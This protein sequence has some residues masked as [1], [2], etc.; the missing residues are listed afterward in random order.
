M[1]LVLM[2]QLTIDP[3]GVIRTGV[4][5]K[6]NA[7]HQPSGCKDARNVIEL[8][9]RCGFEVAVRDLE[10]FSHIWLVW[11]FDRNSTWRP[12]V[13][14]PR[15]SSQRRGVFATRSPHRPN[16]IGLTAVPLLGIDGLNVIVGDV[17]LLDGTPILDIKP[18][19]AMVD[20]LPDATLGWLDEVEEL[21]AT[22]P[23]YSVS[24]S[25]AA[26]NQ[27]DWLKQEWGVDFIDRAI[28]LLS[29]DP[30]V[31][32]TRRIRRLSDDRFQIGCGT[33]RLTFTVQGTQVDI[34]CVSSGYP[35]HLVMGERS[36]LVIEQ[37]IHIAFL[38][39]WALD[40]LL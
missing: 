5:V 20:S 15:G 6:F 33:W 1:E 8:K 35:A 21:H 26:R 27:L 39:T 36:E 17:D 32:R 28:E 4:T 13:M 23:G 19:L 3:I 7:R 16:P 34:E 31:H 9:P 37:D 11:W 10:G 14:P 22:E 30:S 38:Q 2:N 40:I 12:V 25:T 24:V 29:R 18:Y